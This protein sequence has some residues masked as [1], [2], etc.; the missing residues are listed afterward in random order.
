[1]FSED[2][3]LQNSRVSDLVQHFERWMQQIMEANSST[4]ITEQQTPQPSEAVRPQ[5]D[6]NPLVQPSSQLQILRPTAVRTQAPVSAAPTAPVSATAAAAHH[7]YIDPVY[8]Y[9]YQRY[10]QY[11]GTDPDITTQQHMGTYPNTTGQHYTA[12]DHNVNTVQQLNVYT[13]QEYTG[14]QVETNP[15][16]Y[17]E[18]LLGRS[19][20]NEL[21]G[22]SST[23][24]NEAPDTNANE[25][26]DIGRSRLATCMNETMQHPQHQLR[27]AAKNEYGGAQHHNVTCTEQLPASVHQ[28]AHVQNQE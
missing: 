15:T 17:E 24:T 4:S 6:S 19:L 27:Q 3:Q 26:P 16:A 12:P 22:D 2:Q 14:Q 28:A 21:S 11:M 10:Y 18:L 7:G 23:T 25:Q 1:M 8:L 13:S 9:Y 5:A 20:M